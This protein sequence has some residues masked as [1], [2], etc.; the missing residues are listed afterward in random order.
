MIVGQVRCARFINYISHSKMISNIS[1]L[2]LVITNA[3]DDSSEQ[4]DEKRDQVNKKM[5]N[6]K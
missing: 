6:H 4:Y 5:K 1:Y 2:V 3:H